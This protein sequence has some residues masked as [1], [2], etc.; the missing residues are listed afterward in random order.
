M[1]GFD[2]SGVSTEELRQMAGQL[3]AQLD[4]P[5]VAGVDK[6][7]GADFM[8]RAGASF[9]ADPKER[10]SFIKARLGAENV[11]TTANGEVVWRKP[12]DKRWRAFDEAGFSMAD[13]A[14]FAGD[15]PEIVGATAGAVLGAGAAS[16]PGAAA[17][18]ALGN[19]VK[20]GISAMLPGEESGRPIDRLKDVGVSGVMAGGAQ[21]L[22][23]MAFKMLSPTARA[24]QP[25]T[26]FAV[27]GE[28]LAKAVGG[29]LT[30]GQ[31]TGSQAFRV[32]EDYLR[33]NPSAAGIM[34]DFEVEKQIIPIKNYLDKTLA[35]LSSTEVADEALG[36]SFKN[37][38]DRGANLLKDR[39]LQQ[40][41]DDFRF[42]QQALGDTPIFEPQN[43]LGELRLLAQRYGDPT[44]P[45]DMKKYAGKA[46][47]LL[48]HYAGQLQGGRYNAQQ[49]QDLLKTYGKA[50]YGRNPM[51]I[52][53]GLEKSDQTRIARDLFQALNKDLE[54]AAG[55]ANT[56]PVPRGVSVNNVA[57]MLKEARGNYARNIAAVDELGLSLI[58]KKLKNM[59]GQYEPE[60]IAE[61][62]Q[63]L[64]PSGLSATMD[65]METLR[66]GIR[67][68]TARNMMENALKKATEMA[69]TSGTGAAR[70]PL[71]PDYLLKH[72]PD[73]ETL[74]AVLGPNSPAVR[75]IADAAGY[76]ERVVTRNQSAATLQQNPYLS[77]MRHPSHGVP[78]AAQF[79]APRTMARILTD[80]EAIKRL[81][82]L[83]QAAGRKTARA[84]EAIAWLAQ[85]GIPPA[86]LEAG[87]TARD[88]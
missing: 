17:G 42:L 40:G 34:S 48:K 81:R 9:K 25:A 60:R 12:G 69:E 41:A 79:L 51:T 58:G 30:V 53:E 16:V 37:T 54:L 13:I 46:T 6:N 38:F 65:I 7:Q 68:E 43:F 74:K 59:K 86:L 71:S 20:Q 55:A 77:L 75:E 63:K 24:A 72:L 61:W 67:G 47:K 22:G 44:M 64:R 11:A 80:N 78:V 14:D 10:L 19:V 28:R 21:K 32:T 52:L 62:A 3:Q 84:Q 31:K 4:S 76:L 33:R 73:Q 50:G 85:K 70:S 35:K 8:T 45:P 36:A 15:V 27:E 83:K 39:M 88:N 23:N 87:L 1:A 66:P 18:G 5:D 49:M 82:I 29:D 56:L 26:Q 57:K 2:L